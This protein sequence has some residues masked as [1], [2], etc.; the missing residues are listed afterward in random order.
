MRRLS[1]CFL[2]DDLSGMLAVYDANKDGSTFLAS[3]YGFTR[4]DNLSVVRVPLFPFTDVELEDRCALL[5]LEAAK[6]SGWKRKSAFVDA[7]DEF[8]K[9]DYELSCVLTSADHHLIPSGRRIAVAHPEYIGR[10]VISG[11]GNQRGVVLWGTEAIVG[12]MGGART[13]YE[14]VLADFLAA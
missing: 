14:H 7:E 1:D 3:K 4:H 9:R 13:S 11:A 2:R 8:A 12:Y 6:T 5:I 10:I